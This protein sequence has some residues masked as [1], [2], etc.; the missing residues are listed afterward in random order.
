MHLLTRS[1]R[2]A[3]NDGPVSFGRN[4]YAGN[5][6]IRGFGRWIEIV[7]VCRGTI[8]PDTGYLIDIK[9]IDARVRSDALPILQQAVEAGDNPLHVLRS[10]AAVLAA[11]LP[12]T[13]HCLRLCL[14]PYHDL[15]M[16]PADPSHA[17][18]RQ[19]FDFSAAHRLHSPA[20]SDEENLRLY[21]KCNNPRGHGHNYVVQPVVKVRIDSSPAFSLSDLESITDDAVIKPFDHKHLNEDTPEFCVAKGG[22]LPSVENIARICFERLRPAIAAHPAQPV[23]QSVTVWETDRTSATYPA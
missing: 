1:V 5:P 9:A 18:I 22:V 6:P 7:V 2:F 10:S 8:H 12:S 17:L 14:T 11:N 15:E 23:L 16:S 13:L 20:L 21:G 4:G 3:L 19:R